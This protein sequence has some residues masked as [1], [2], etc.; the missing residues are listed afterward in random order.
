MPIGFWVAL[1]YFTASVFDIQLSLTL[2]LSTLL[3]VSLGATFFSSWIFSFI[4]QREAEIKRRAS[5]L[6]ALNAA[7]LAL[8]AELELGVVLQKVADLSRELVNARYGA[9][10]V[11]DENG[12][13]IERFIT[14]GIPDEKHALI[15]RPP[16]G[17]GVLGEMIREGR[18]I[19]IAS[20][21]N[22]QNTVGFPKHHPHMTSLLGVPIISKGTVIGDLYLTDKLPEEGAKAERGGEFSEQDQQLLEMF[23]TQA[24]IAIE[25]A[26]LYRQVQQLAVLQER[27]RFGMDLHDGVIQSIYAV[28]L[29]LENLQ[30]RIQSDATEATPGITRAVH[31]L[32][33]IISDIRNYILDLRPQRFQGR[34][35][36]QGL[37]ELVRSLRANTFMGVSLNVDSVSA[38]DLSPEQTVEILHITQE[39]LTNVRKHARAS[40]VD[41]DL[42]R[43]DGGLLL[44]IEDDGRT[45]S[46][47][48]IQETKGNGLRNMRDRARGIQG[49]FVV[50]PR[51]DGGTRVELRVPAEALKSKLP[52]PL[53]ET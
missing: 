15:G 8:N 38:K 21:T 12:E 20:I 46:Q 18:P 36:V 49:E 31:A 34:D 1:L 6:E 27:E 32:S 9:L 44:R 5:Q 25:N 28:G 17:E 30:R 39:A 11:L 3:L 19:R 48:D 4:D 2:V 29:M 14:S 45:I 53:L 47:A 43:K 16:S 10:G 13:Y 42:R 50:E 33:D 26:K 51:Q 35:L 40:N 41:I 22:H 23:A 52:T 7:A 37:T 24:A